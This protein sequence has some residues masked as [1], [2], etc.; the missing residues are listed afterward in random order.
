MFD[1]LITI[2]QIEVHPQCFN[3]EF[4]VTFLDPSKML[5]RNVG[6]GWSQPE[7]IVEQLKLQ[8]LLNFACIHAH[9]YL[10]VYNKHSF[11]VSK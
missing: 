1:I 9:V 2:S 4:R 11:L 6:G 3:N 7:L 10:Y 5:K 8:Q